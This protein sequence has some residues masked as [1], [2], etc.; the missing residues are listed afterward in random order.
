MS[1]AVFLD[2]GEVL[3]DNVKAEP[4]WDRYVGQFYSERFGGNPDRWAGAN[5]VAFEHYIERYKVEAWGHPEMDYCAFQKREWRRLVKR[6]FDI[7]NVNPPSN[8]DMFATVVEAHTW[9]NK[10]IHAEIPG[11]GE[12][13][14][15]LYGLGYRLYACSGINST[16]LRARL[17]TMEIAAYFLRLYGPDLINRPKV[18]PLYYPSI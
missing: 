4:Q 17:E 13:V 9:I 10:Q 3:F 5:R 14:R 1:K 18:G 12:T 15:R 16:A 6:M 11:A 2:C 7:M 8:D